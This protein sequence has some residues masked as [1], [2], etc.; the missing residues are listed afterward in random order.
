MHDFAVR[1]TP[2]DQTCFRIAGFV[3]Q[4]DLITEIAP[5]TCQYTQLPPAACRL[6][7]V[8][9]A[10]PWDSS[11]QEGTD[12][13]IER[14][15]ATLADL[16]EWDR[17][18]RQE[19]TQQEIRF[20]SAAA[21]EYGEWLLRMVLLGGEQDLTDTFDRCRRG[22]E[23][24]GMFRIL[25]QVE[26]NV[27][28]RGATR[29]WMQLSRLSFEVIGAGGAS[30]LRQ[31]GCVLY[32][33]HDLDALR[34]PP[35]RSVYRTC[36]TYIG[37]AGPD[38]ADALPTLPLYTLFEHLEP[39]VP[40]RTDPPSV[41]KRLPGV[42]EMRLSADAIRAVS[43]RYQVVILVAHGV[44][45]GQGLVVNGHATVHSQETVGIPEIGR[46]LATCRARLAVIVSCQKRDPSGGLP[47]D[48]G[49]VLAEQCF[50][51]EQPTLS[52]IV[53]FRSQ[54]LFGSASAFLD[55]LSAHLKD[56]CQSGL[57]RLDKATG[58]ARYAIVTHG[59]RK[60]DDNWDFA[61]PAVYVRNEVEIRPPPPAD[62]RWV[63]LTRTGFD[64]A[65]REAALRAAFERAG[66]ESS[67]FRPQQM[68]NRPSE[69]QVAM[70]P[71]TRAEVREQLT[72][73]DVPATWGQPGDDDDLPATGLT[74]TGIVRY[75]ESLN[76]RDDGWRY[77]LPNLVQWISAAH[78][79]GTELF[80]WGDGWDAGK[81]NVSGSVVSVFE[82]WKHANGVFG[83]IGNCWEVLAWPQPPKELR[84]MGGDCRTAPWECSVCCVKKVTPAEFDAAASPQL[85]HS[86]TPPPQIGFRLVRWPA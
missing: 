65:A 40:R 1:L 61:I 21:M 78:A 7:G 64:F 42:L 58:A 24:D 69:H 60:G 15:E 80:P 84:L 20:R 38:N 35:E 37:V 63:Q 34:L 74:M 71:V 43:E 16:F 28:E 45:G 36:R 31:P 27:P 22:G 9:D 53:S 57:L 75:L 18:E 55:S 79:G 6:L 11:V 76:A 49:Q 81:A 62:M 32:R 48:L 73:A 54:F 47:V 68:P 3:R 72:E 67:L 70:F 23:A 4:G 56:A 83:M 13:H 12:T 14:V 59:P 33:V 44:S 51:A 52:A 29:P 46:F 82:T 66:G 77:D 17:R 5:R 2:I 50:R 85:R 10:R 41:L 39:L 8:R 19:L 25:L 26:G 30:L 86:R